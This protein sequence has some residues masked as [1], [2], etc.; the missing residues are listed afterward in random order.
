MSPYSIVSVS[1]VVQRGDW[2]STFFYMN[3]SFSGLASVCGYPLVDGIISA[4]LHVIV[5]ILRT[6]IL[7]G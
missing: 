3:A 5:L 2:V 7:H 1:G 6:E 4:Q